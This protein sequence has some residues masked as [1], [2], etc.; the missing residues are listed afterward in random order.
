MLVTGAGG[1]IGSELCLQIC[2]YRPRVL[3]LLEL[4]EYNL[5]HIEMAIKSA[6]PNITVLP[7]IGSV[8]DKSVVEPIMSGHSPSIV[9]HAAAYKH[10]PMM[11]MNP[12]QAIKN[13][14]FGT[15]TLV[16]MAQKYGV[17]R[18]V[19]I[20][21]DK[22][23]RPTSLMGATKRVGELITQSHADEAKLG[24]ITVR[25]GNVVGSGGS[26]APL[27]IGQIKKGDR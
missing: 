2:R 6:F 5:Y 24:F 13:N 14:V 25:F 18:F 12:L 11:E 21:T 19:F 8:A 16:S 20:S 22:A 7:F 15:S 1:S 4:S 3:L 23:V 17:G 9:F 27:F 26:V 10:V